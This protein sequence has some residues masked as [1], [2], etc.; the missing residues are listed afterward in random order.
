MACSDLTCFRQTSM[1]STPA[2]L[3]YP[4]DTFRYASSVIR[5]GRTEQ[6]RVP[7]A[8]N[9]SVSSIITLMP[10]VNISCSVVSHKIGTIA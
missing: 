9:I 4:A 6:A 8:R 10:T 5:A 7:P 3:A 2:P 1:A